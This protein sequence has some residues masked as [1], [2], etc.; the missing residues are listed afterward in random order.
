MVSFEALKSGMERNGEVMIRLKMVEEIELHKQNVRFEN[1][2]R[3]IVVGSNTNEIYVYR[4][5]LT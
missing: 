3:E 1:A 5:D 2:T 4:T